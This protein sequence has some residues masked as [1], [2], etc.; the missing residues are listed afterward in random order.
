LTIEPYKDFSISGSAVL[1][2]PYTTYWEALETVLKPGRSSSSVV[3]VARYH[4]TD[5]TVEINEL[6]EWFG[7]RPPV[8]SLKNVLSHE[9]PNSEPLHD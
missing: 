2:P 8:S 1:G 7:L 5:F 6:A 4:L 9:T 3:E